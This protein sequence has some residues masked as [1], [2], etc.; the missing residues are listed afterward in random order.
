LSF[1]VKNSEDIERHK[2]VLQN[3]GVMIALLAPLGFRSEWSA[4]RG[5]VKVAAGSFRIEDSELTFFSPG[6]DLLERRVNAFGLKRGKT[7]TAPFSERFSDGGRRRAQAV[8]VRWRV[9]EMEVEASLMESTTGLRVVYLPLQVRVKKDPHIVATVVNCTGATLN[10]AE[11]VRGA[12]CFADG[13]PFPSTTG[14]H[15]D[16]GVDVQPGKAATK[17]FSLDDFPG[18]PRAG[19]HKMSLQILG[20]VSEI[21]TVDW[22]T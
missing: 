10:I 6:G 1:C 8:I 2:D 18:V 17:Q 20:L 15:W 3:D 13:K 16:G 4:L 12:V 9:N 11:G 5:Y 7:F 22:R 14:G 19:Q 21:E